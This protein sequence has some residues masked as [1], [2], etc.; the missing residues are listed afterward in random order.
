MSC[1]RTVKTRRLK[2]LV[3]QASV[4][5]ADTRLEQEMF[6]R[7]C[8]V[9]SND[10]GGGEQDTSMTKTRWERRYAPQ[11]QAY[12]QAHTKSSAQQGQQRDQERH[13]KFDL[14]TSLYNSSDDSLAEPV[15]MELVAARATTSSPTIQAVLEERLRVAN[16]EYRNLDAIREYEDEGEGACSEASSLSD[17]CSGLE[18]EQ[19]TV[20][21][22]MKAGPQ[23][24]QFVGLLESIMEEEEEELNDSAGSEVAHTGMT[25]ATPLTTTQPTQIPVEFP[26]Y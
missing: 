16:E 6:S 12:A 18:G 7:H 11:A 14:S 25:Q 4:A 8:L 1:Y 24:T 19:Y 23:F 5:S 9:I 3:G 22:L 26:Y 10:P 20:D 2:Y 17:I 21:H 15:N 13:V